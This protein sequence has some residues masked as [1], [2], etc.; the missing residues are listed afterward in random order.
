MGEKKSTK[1]CKYCQTEIPAKAKVCPKCRKKQGLGCLPIIIIVIVVILLLSLLF[2]GGSDSNEKENGSSQ[3][4][5]TS[6]GEGGGQDSAEEIDPEEY[7]AECADLVYN[8]VMRN[9]D[10]YIGSK[11]KVTAQ[12][13]QASDGITTG[14]YYKVFTDDGSGYYFD[15]MIWVF[16]KRD[17][18]SEDY[19]K[20][21]E[22]DVVTFYGEFNGLQ[23]TENS[24]NG[25]KGED[26]S[27]DVYYAEIVKEAE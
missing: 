4:T 3:G 19:V 23:E 20:L 9:P 10:D 13:M 18:K 26:M 6:S 21:L 24:L 17:E 7:K 12:I 27:L 2:S 1:L 5:E 8:D 11:F 16:D 15:K 22:D 25:S 14:K